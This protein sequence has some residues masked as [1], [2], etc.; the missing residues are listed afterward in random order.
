MIFAKFSPLLRNLKDEYLCFDTYKFTALQP[1][2]Y[3]FNFFIFK[4]EL[5][6]KYEAMRTQETVLGN[7]VADIVAAST[8]ADL[9][10][11]NSG[12]FRSDGIHPKGEFRLNDLMT[13]L[14]IADTVVT[15][16]ATG[17]QLLQIFENGVSK[18]PRMDGRFPQVNIL[19]IES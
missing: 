17:K 12:S 8:K 7:F 6:G 9:V 5:N 15:V 3:S 19:F 16:L 2:N 4:N 13:I 14:P 18:Y 10:L 1:T 11:I